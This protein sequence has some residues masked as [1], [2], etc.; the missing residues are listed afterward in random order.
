MTRRKELALLWAPASRH[1]GGE[2]INQQISNF[3]CLF[4]GRQCFGFLFEVERNYQN[5]FQR[6]EIKM[7][8]DQGAFPPKGI[9]TES[10]IFWENQPQF[11]S[12]P[13]P[14]RKTPGE[15]VQ[16]TILAIRLG[17]GKGV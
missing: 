9:L 15:K 5:T 4:S 8:S 16:S 6:D 2:R 17:T 13:L 14:R 1:R 11:F 7:P 3:H 12:P 10:S